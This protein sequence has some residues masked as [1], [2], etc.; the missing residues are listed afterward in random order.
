[1]KAIQTDAKNLPTE[2]SASWKTIA[3]G[4]Q[5]AALDL[6]DTLL[7][8][9]KEISSVTKQA[10][11]AWLESG[12]KIIIATGRPPRLARQIP[13]FLHSHPRICYNGAWLEHKQKVI[14]QNPIP[15]KSGQE[16][17]K[18]VFSEFPDLWVGYEA[19]DVHFMSRE[20][21]DRQATI[22][23]LRCLAKPA[24]KIVFKPSMVTEFQL[25][26]IK[27]MRPQG[28]TWLR[29]DMYDLVQVAAQGTDK[30]GTLQWWLQSE[31]FSLQQTLAIGDDSNDSGMLARSGMG[32][33]M[34]N[35]ADSVKES[36]DFITSDNQSGGVA[37][38]L[39]R[40][41]DQD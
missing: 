36:A 27:S 33:A 30:S 2:F 38:V 17:M 7:T 21:L 19:D 40:V 5:V 10:L 9:G 31:G 15:A 12:K 18:R 34:A 13:R 35:A 6:D 20:S 25:D 41:L 26:L 8:K 11:E 23:D 14:F 24:Y 1:M 4:L 29:S 3:M 32:V 39:H 37:R 28:T 16:F 22:C